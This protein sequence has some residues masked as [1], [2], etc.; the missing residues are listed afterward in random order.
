[1]EDS[2]RLQS[3]DQLPSAAQFASQ[4]ESRNVP[5][6]FVGCVKDWK[7]VS[8][9]NPSNG[10]LGYL[11][12]RVGSFMV[13]AML[14]QTA[15]VFYGDLRSH[16]RVPLPFSTFIGFCKWHR[17][18]VGNSCSINSNSQ[19]HQLGE[20]DTEQGC[21]TFV[22]AAPKQIYLAQIPIINA[23]NEARVQLETLQEDIQLPAILEGKNLSSINLWMNIAQA[24]SSAH[25]DP[26]HNLLCIVTGRKQV[27]LWPPSAS[28]ML[29]PMPIYG[30]ASNHSSVALENPD[31][32]IHPRAQ[33][34]MEY[35]Q[36]VTLQ[37]GDALFI[38]EGWF[39]QVDSD[40]LTMAVNYWWRSSI[41]SSLADHMDAYYLRR[42]LRRLTD[43]EMDQ[44]LL[45]GS[46]PT[47]RQESNVDHS[48]DQAGQS[49]DLKRK[50][51]EQHSL[52]LHELRPCALQALHELVAL[53][54]D[55]VNASDQNQPVSSDSTNGLMCSKT[56]EQ[57]KTLT[58][59]IFHLEEDPVAKILW[60]LEPGIFKDI[61]LAMA[62]NF[63]RTLEALVLHLL[64][65]VGAEVLT[66]KFDEIDQ[67][68]TEENQ[69][70]FYQIFYG[71]FDNQFAAMD[72]ILNGKE[73][74]ARQAFKNVLDKYVG[75]NFDVPKL[76]VGRDI[77]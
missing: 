42:I 57:D 20:S 67:Q 60:I 61:F 55:R 52:L 63:P 13:E 36:K 7:A 74:F 11:E 23:E 15:P 39:H 44:V 73:S 21:S 77:S 33:C 51:Q 62:H 45:K 66:R 76:S 34:S 54:H 8:K 17:Q 38:P 37:A 43:R 41:M 27:V 19:G 53:V 65:P 70:K 14:S 50:E 64:S 49:K 72:A 16:E 47:W 24:R 22:D 69:N 12:E 5:A 75:G 26:H 59:E 48:L 25:Y 32:S 10:G 9:W 3:F 29:Y 2:L 28:P 35:S 6:V 31:F 30:E 18:N 1:M 68:N 58:T 40:E 46:T 71:V 56:N 4:I